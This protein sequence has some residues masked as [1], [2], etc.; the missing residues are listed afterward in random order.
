MAPFCRI[1]LAE[2][3]PYFTMSIKPTI[4]CFAETIGELNKILLKKAKEQKLIRGRKLRL[5]TTVVE[6]NIYYINY[7]GLLQDGINI[8]TRTEKNQR[9]VSGCKN[10]LL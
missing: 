2:K 1:S 10:L 4:K 3:I 8:I 7:A 6:S 9:N 5:D